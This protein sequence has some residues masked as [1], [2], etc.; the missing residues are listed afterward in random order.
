MLQRIA[1]RI[2]DSA[3]FSLIELMV[4]VVIAAVLL[5]IA[6]PGYNGQVRKSRRTEAK[7]ALLDLAGREE[8][9]YNMSNPPAYS[10]LPSDL[11][12]NAAPNSFPMTVGSGYYRVSIALSAAVPP[13]TPAGYTFTAVPITADQLKDTQCQTFSLTST[14]L[15]TSAPNT[16]LCW[17]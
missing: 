13:A 8:R 14:G 11:G 1:S 9:L 17:Q 15:Q 16:T 7:T 3:G 6:I 2:P 10:V 12:Y 5:S 4:T